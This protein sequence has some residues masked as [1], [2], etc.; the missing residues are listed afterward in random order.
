MHT[1]VFLVDFQLGKTISFPCLTGD[2]TFLRMWKN[3]S[4]YKDTIWAFQPFLRTKISCLRAISLN[5]AISY[6]QC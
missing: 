3:P 2:K 5:E 1:S 6:C 4:L